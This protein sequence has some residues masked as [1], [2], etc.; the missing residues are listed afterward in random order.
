[1]SSTSSTG[2]VALFAGL[3]PYPPPDLPA[4]VPGPDPRGLA[5]VT[6]S[7]FVLLASDAPLNQAALWLATGHDG[8]PLLAQRLLGEEELEAL[9]ADGRATLLTDR[10]APVDQMLA[11]V[12]REEML[13]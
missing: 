12:F 6:R 2:R 3:C 4:R 11:P 9:L 13:P 5:A 7:T 8:V 10:Y 1:M